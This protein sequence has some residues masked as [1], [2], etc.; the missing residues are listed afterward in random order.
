MARV[1]YNIRCRDKEA[2]VK[3]K[4][5]EGYT[6]QVGELKFGVTNTSPLPEN[7]KYDVWTVTELSTGYSCAVAGKKSEAIDYVLKEDILEKVKIGIEKAGVED[8][9]KDIIASTIYYPQYK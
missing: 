1:I 6:F 5:V 2:E 7:R 9:N 3:V 8:I 4:Q